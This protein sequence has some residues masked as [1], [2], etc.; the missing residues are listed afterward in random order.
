M[1]QSSG[2]HHQLAGLKK[3][4]FEQCLCSLSLSFFLFS[5]LSILLSSLP[6]S[7]FS[8]PCSFFLLPFFLSSSPF[9]SHLYFLPFFLPFS[10]IPSTFPHPSLNSCLSIIYFPTQHKG[11]EE[12]PGTAAFPEPFVQG[13]CDLGIKKPI[14]N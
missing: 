8:F 4:Q 7:P 9:P 13:C 2:P 10:S 14:F 5:L 11:E 12:T 6:L 3:L 1:K